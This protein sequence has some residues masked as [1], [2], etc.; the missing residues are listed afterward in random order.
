K[1]A[2][3]GQDPVIQVSKA[4]LHLKEDDDVVARPQAKRQEIQQYEAPRVS[5][6]DLVPPQQ[7]VFNQDELRILANAVTDT[8]KSFKMNGEVTDV[9]VGPVVT[10][11][12]F[13]PS[14]GVKVKG[15]LGLADDLAMA[16]K[17][18]SVRIAPIPAKG[19]VGIEIPSA[20]RLTIYLRELMSSAEFQD[21]KMHL[22]CIIGKDVE[23]GAVIDD[24]TKMTHLLIGGT[25]G[26]GKSVGVNGILMSLLYK[27]SPDQLRLLLVDPKQLEFKLYDGIPHLLHPVV[28]DP[29]AAAIALNWACR[30]MERRYTIMARW[31]TRNIVEHNEKVTR[32]LA[33]WTR[34]K[35]L[36]YAPKEWAGGIPDPPETMPFLV[37]VIDE[38]AD[39][40]MVAK[41]GVEES[42][43]RLAQKARA[44][45][46]HLILS[47][48]RPSVDV[49]TGL[50]K[51]NMPTRITFKLRSGI[52][53]RTILDQ[54]GAE[55]LLGRGDLLLMPNGGNIDL[56]R[57]HGAFVSSAEVERVTDH[58]RKQ[59]N[60]EY[61]EAITVEPEECEVDESMRDVMY[62]DALEIVRQAGKASTSMLQRHLK[63]GY[64]RAAN[65]IEFMEK[66][67]VIGPA[68]G[69]KPREVLIGHATTP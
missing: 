45:G 26:S 54:V 34:E 7:A 35:A 49:V 69:A 37:V 18:D 17:V 57:C 38:L 11:F 29:K 28:T 4:K 14:R 2:K 33:D 42:V 15:I 16:L 55:R 1:K 30:E 59:G 32:E 53:S 22:P 31:G 47:T 67:G 40:M 10:I 25:T 61:V 63:I 64:N 66:L 48:Q 50:I 65:I 13:K 41:K 5:L 46:I 24:L 19:V 12:Q 43:V 56:M 8:L 3:N 52:D 21:A 20:S 6:L 9:T 68:D 44:C 27:C 62:D 36:A 39:L 51:S 23:G 60:P 58:L